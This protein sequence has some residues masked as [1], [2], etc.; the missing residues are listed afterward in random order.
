[1]KKLIYLII[2]LMFVTALPEVSYAQSNDPFE[3]QTLKARGNATKREKKIKRRQNQAETPAAPVQ[4]APVQEAPAPV[5]KP[6]QVKP[7]ELTISNP[8]DDWLSFELISVIGSKGTQSVKI[9]AKF[10]NHGMNKNIQVG[11]QL[12]AY[13]CDGVEHYGN[14]YG[15]ACSFSTVTDVPVKFS[16][17]IP[18]KIN[19]ATT[20]ILPVV[21][22]DID[23]CRIEIKN[24]PI[25]WK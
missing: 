2:A 5:E 13:D 23:N 6:K 21:S 20:Q 12:L 11:H 10:T 22:F 24:V 4:E 8:C 14:W 7:G 18:G 25:N 17:E 16:L 9:T 19:P 3:Q 15:Y 1:M